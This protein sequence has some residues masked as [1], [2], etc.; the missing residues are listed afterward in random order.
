[1][2]LVAF[3]QWINP[4]QTSR[5]L[6]FCVVDFFF[7]NKCNS[8]LKRYPQCQKSPFHLSLLVPSWKYPFCH[9]KWSPWPAAVPNP[10]H[11]P[12]FLHL[13]CDLG[14]VWKNGAFVIFHQYLF[15]SSKWTPK[16]GEREILCSSLICRGLA[17]WRPG[18]CS[19]VFNTEQIKL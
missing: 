3:T 2:N 12:L 4:W 11:L 13:P 7:F 8:D 16:W 10:Y 17:F 18:I 15:I 19:I 6:E 5:S 1:M 9:M 14:K